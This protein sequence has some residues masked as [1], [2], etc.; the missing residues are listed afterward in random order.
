[1]HSEAEQVTFTSGGL[2]VDDRGQLS[3][4]NELDLRK[5]KR[6]YL[7]SN[8]RAEFV[9]AW[10]GHKQEAKGVVVV[11]GAAIVA[12][13]PIEDWDTPAKE[14]VVNR[15]VLSD[16]KPGILEIP[17]GYANGFKTLEEETILCFFSTSSLE[18]SA[19]DDFRFPANYWDPWN[20]EER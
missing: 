20:V 4:I 8:H 5:Y 16:K 19:S 6:F 18:E 7:V 2:S 15:Y 1:M 9:R 3:F 14:T 17:P 10:H 11:K 13:V 12:A